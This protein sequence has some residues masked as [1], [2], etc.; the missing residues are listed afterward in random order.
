MKE[1]KILFIGNSYTYY[2][3]MPDK[4]FYSKAKEAGRYFKVF[5]IVKGGYKLSQYVDPENPYGI[6]LREMIRDEHFD[7]IVLQD[8]SCNPIVNREDFLYGVSSL[9][10]LLSDH[11]DHFVL[12]ATWGRKTGS[13]DLE[14]LQ[15]SSLEMTQKL[16]EAYDL[17]GEKFGMG[18]A[19]VGMVFAERSRQD[20]SVDLYDED[21]THPSL[22]GSML[23]A[24]TILAAIN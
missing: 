10:E 8:Q 21:M 14:K 19:H 5:T 2:H 4:L 11:A 6:L 24:E 7:Y 22:A 13:P 15:I 1:E 23:A 18:V 3:D 12:Y 17:A 16:A 9:K 20:P